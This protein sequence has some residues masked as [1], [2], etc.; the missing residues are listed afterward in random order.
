MYHFWYVVRN[1]IGKSN[2]I[3]IKLDSWNI[4][5]NRIWCEFIYVPEMVRKVVLCE[6]KGT[7]D[8]RHRKIHIINKKM[9]Y[10]ANMSL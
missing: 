9:L 10:G 6:N 7:M 3:R 8:E 2:L 5:R 4:M 1:R